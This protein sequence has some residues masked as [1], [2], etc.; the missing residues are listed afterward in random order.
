M[1]H[2]QKGEKIYTGKAKSLFRVLNSNQEIEPSLVWFHF[3]DSMT[4]FNAQK[5]AE[6]AGKGSMNL[7]ITEIVFDHLRAFQIPTAWVE[8]IGPEDVIMRSLSM[9]PLELIVR[10]AA[11]GSFVKRFGVEKGKRFQRP[12]FETS[13]K[14]DAL[15]D[16]LITQDEAIEL[17]VLA[18]DHDWYELKSFALVINS[19]LT[20]LF[21]MIGFQLVDFKIEV[22]RDPKTGDLV[23]ADEISPDSCRLWD[24]RTGEPFDKDRFRLDLGSVSEGYQAV[25]QRLKERVL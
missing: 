21:E 14:N 22:G 12:L 8:R 6:I 16:P 18:S 23:L 17:E 10:N 4:A 2:W 7:A 20:A 15:G 1:S 13:F 24:L 5:R 3:Q 19:H 11:A 25:L 9:V